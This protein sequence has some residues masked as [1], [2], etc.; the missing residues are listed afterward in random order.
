MFARGGH[1]SCRRAR[2]G[3]CALEGRFLGVAL[4]G[5]LSMSCERGPTYHRDV[6]PILAR[7]C[8][9]CHG[10]TGLAAFPRLDG[11]EPLGALLE[12]VR[13][14]VQNRAMPPWGADDTGQCGR[15]RDS[16]WLSGAEIET[17]VRFA[18]RGGPRGAPVPSPP[19]P[20]PAPSLRADAWVDVGRDDTPGLG[21]G[22]YRCFLVDPGLTRDRLLTGVEVQASDPRGVAQVTLYALESAR[23][24]VQAAALDALDDRPGWPCFDGPQVTPARPI[25]SWSWTEATLE[26]PAGTGVRLR[27][28]RKLVLEV[29]YDLASAGLSSR[30]RIRA[31]LRL[32]DGAGGELAEAQ[33]VP[34]R[35]S[36]FRLPPGQVYAETRA[37]LVVPAPW[38][39]LGAAPR[40][41]MLGRAMQLDRRAPGGDAC[42]ANFSHWSFYRQQLFAYAEPVRLDPGDRLSVA[43]VYDTEGR[44]APV[45]AGE[46][47][48]D[49]QCL[50]WLYVTP[51]PPGSGPPRSPAPPA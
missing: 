5:A 4:I 11:P 42:L 48:A 46:G 1:R 47:I 36:G 33:L 45:A 2:G 27:A 9:R 16:P 51:R 8:V 12:K 3:A 38:T 22:A 13:L 7:R 39:L 19:P 17:L 43:C 14:A 26:Y 18:E 25:G 31:A 10:P 15:W 30:T 41:H 28:T 34:V 32:G 6:E 44:D 49:E 23:A 40:M 24:E 50:V 35:A 37:D 20:A 21:E 29:H